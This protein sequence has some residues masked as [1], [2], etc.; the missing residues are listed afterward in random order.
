MVIPKMEAQSQHV[1]HAGLGMVAGPVQRLRA[2]GNGENRTAAYL[3][4]LFTMP[5][6][7]QGMG[8]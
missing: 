4:T 6:R 3:T 1:E 8:S 7:E 2:V 5:W